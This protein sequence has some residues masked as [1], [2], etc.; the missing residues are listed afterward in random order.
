[1]PVPN[2]PRILL[3]KKRKCRRIALFSL[4]AALL[5]WLLFF[6]SIR[7]DPPAPLPLT[8][9]C[10]GFPFVLFFVSALWYFH[11]KLFPEYDLDGL[12]EAERRSLTVCPAYTEACRR[13]RRRR[14]GKLLLLVVL[15]FA[16]TSGIVLGD[17]VPGL[18]AVELLSSAA[19]VLLAG[20]LTLDVSRRRALEYEKYDLG[21]P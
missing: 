19:V 20:S 11:V 5:L 3:R 7:M 18:W 8:L 15:V 1:M 16:G 17:G 10:G 21:R 14:T 4:L 9:F 2:T 13:L 12:T 6:I